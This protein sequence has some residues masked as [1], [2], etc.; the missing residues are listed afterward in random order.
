MVKFWQRDNIAFASFRRRTYHTV[1]R[2]DTCS[3]RRMGRFYA[4]TSFTRMATWNRRQPQMSLGDSG[5]C[6]L[7]T[8]MGHLPTI[9]PLHRRQN[10]SCKSSLPSS[11]EPSQPCTAC[12]LYTSD[13]ADDLL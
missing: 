8:K 5:K 6:S 11:R 3:K 1:G 4:Q 10:D 13:A 2:R 12:L 9:C 7:I